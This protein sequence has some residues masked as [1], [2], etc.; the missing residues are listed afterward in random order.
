MTLYR[1]RMF[2]VLF[3]SSVKTIGNGVNSPFPRVANSYCDD[4]FLSPIGDYRRQHLSFSNEKPGKKSK[5]RKR[6]IKETFASTFIDSASPKVLEFVTVGFNTTT[7]HLEDL[8]QKCTGNT[9]PESTSPGPVMEHRA[10]VDSHSIIQK[11]LVAIFVPRAEQPKILHSHLP[12]LI[13]AASLGSSALPPIRLVPLASGA[14]A[15]LIKAL[16]IPRVGLVGLMD[17]APAASQLIQLVRT[18]VPVVEIPWLQESISGVF[19]PTT[20]NTIH[21]TTS[22]ESKKKGRPKGSTKPKNDQ[23]PTSAC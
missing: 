3:P 22:A 8:A 21:T 6:S 20:I 11:P 13:Q 19:L 15:R 12:V 17:N 9:A 2:S 16:G 5:K 4:S 14:E 1:S 7:R 23:K 10:Q 18:Q